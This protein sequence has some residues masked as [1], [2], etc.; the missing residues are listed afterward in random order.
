MADISIYK[1]PD[2]PAGFKPPKPVDLLQRGK[3][4]LR[5]YWDDVRPLMRSMSGEDA[6]ITGRPAGDEWM[7][8][9][10]CQQLASANG[11]ADLGSLQADAFRLLLRRS[12]RSHTGTAVGRLIKQGNQVRLA[13]LRAQRE[14]EE[15]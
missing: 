10:R 9:F 5:D 15:A 6:S 3:S 14:A 2:S 7:L 11:Y 4:F 1:V 13:D 12:Y 8:T